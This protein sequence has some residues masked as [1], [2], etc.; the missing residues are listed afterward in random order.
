MKA[1]L[2]TIYDSRKSFGNKAMVSDEE[3][4]N[5]I[6]LISYTTP[7]AEVETID[8]VKQARVFGYFSETTARHINEF[9]QQN[10]FR[11]LRKSEME[12]G[13]VL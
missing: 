5:V 2:A 1:Y 10:G 4:D 11:K 9:L 12:G 6:T 13:I 3:K 8:G 7:V